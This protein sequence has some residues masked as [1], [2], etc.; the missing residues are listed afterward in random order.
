MHTHLA[1]L[2]PLRRAI[3]H[4]LAQL[5]HSL[6]RITVRVR[7]T[8]VEA[9]AQAAAEVVR[10]ASTPLL[11][12]AEEFAREP[13]RRPHDSSLIWDD[14]GLHRPE[15]GYAGYEEPPD[16]DWE[17]YE[18]ESVPETTPAVPSRLQ[19]ALATGCR[20]TAWLLDRGGCRPLTK[21]LGAGVLTA[22]AA[23]SGGP[24]IAAG[25]G[26]IGT[27]ATWLSLNAG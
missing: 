6:V 19:S 17:E 8:V 3:R 14:D 9:V 18:P 5:H 26:L 22:L 15:Y 24:A 25:V 27:L 12:I 2:R 11:P 23:F 1:W 16:P 10:Q 7:D 20:V 13:V 4:A 21:A